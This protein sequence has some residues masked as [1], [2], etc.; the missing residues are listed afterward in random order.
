[1]L[2]TLDGLQ[3]NVP[4]AMIKRWQGMITIGICELGGGVSC[5]SGI[6]MGK[7]NTTNGGHYQSLVTELG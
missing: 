4:P 7:V 3:M 5:N 6:T 2:P 1:M